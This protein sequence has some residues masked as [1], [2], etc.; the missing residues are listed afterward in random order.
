MSVVKF[1]RLFGIYFRFFIGLVSICSPSIGY[2]QILIRADKTSFIEFSA[3]AQTESMKTFTEYQ[4]EKIRISPRPVQLKSLLEKA[5]SKF[6]SHDP[7][8][9][10]P[11]YQSIIHQ[12]H[13][14]DWEEEE[15][16]IIFYSFLRLA[17][18]ERNV[19]KS[20]LLLKEAMIFEQDLKLDFKLF[21]PPLV[22]AYQQI[23][24][25][26][27]LTSL[28]LKNIFPIHEVVL[29]NGRMYQN[30]QKLSLP[31]GTYRI[32]A[33]SSSHNSWSEVISLSHLILKKFKPHLWLQENVR[34]LN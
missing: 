27:L 1:H 14:F 8:S 15:R 2:S 31:Y 26:S 9:A 19:H 13:S 20:K 25:S 32:T 16:K 6:L 30:T 12:A 4:L 33:L 24:K 21:P 29:I 22:K 11:V 10:K 18:L 17:Q 23:K 7:E 5:Q 3:Y 28:D 34:K